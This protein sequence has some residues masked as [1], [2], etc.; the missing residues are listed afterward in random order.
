MNDE[1]DDLTS[2]E[3]EGMRRW[4]EDWQP[5]DDLRVRTVRALAE[6]NR[7]STTP[8]PLRSTAATLAWVAAAAV[9]AFVLG[10]GVGERRRTPDP[11]RP[12]QSFMLLLFESDAYRVAQGEDEQRKRVGEYIAWAQDISAGGRYVDGEEL[13]QVGQRFGLEAG[14][15][16][17][18]PQAG[19][20]QAG[21]LAGYFVV[22]AASANEAARLLD[23]CPHLKYGGTVEVRRIE[24]H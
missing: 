8:R 13:D 21:V 14:R 24:N 23:G 12:P 18:L 1:R 7:P 19:D 9:V 2:A 16:T 11:S 4:G 22:G 6:G 17:H 15:L 10:F 3:R 20:P 5:P